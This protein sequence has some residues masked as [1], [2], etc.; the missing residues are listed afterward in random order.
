MIIATGS[1]QG[2][3]TPPGNPAYNVAKAGVLHLSKLAAADLAR[4]RIRVNAI[5]PGFIKT[6]IFATS[7]EVPEQLRDRVNDLIAGFA[8]QA[9]P[10]AR[11]GTPEDI[12]GAV[13][14][15]ASDDAAFVTGTHLL[16][17]GGILVGPRHSWDPAAPRMTDA[18]RQLIDAPRFEKV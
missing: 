6:N 2:I 18:I 15:L 12:A 11:G 8:D 1:K 4:H 13:A 14:F 7:M 9:Q 3:T 5:C 17:D 10:V 16:V